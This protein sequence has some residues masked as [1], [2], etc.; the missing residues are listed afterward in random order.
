MHAVDATQRSDDPVSRI[1]L[2]DCG[3]T[4]HHVSC[5]TGKDVLPSARLGV[6]SWRLAGWQTGKKSEADVR[7][8]DLYGGEVAR[9]SLLVRS[10]NVRNV[11]SASQL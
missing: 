10:S 5:V 2:K 4:R 9:V 3:L 7:R 6:K 8:A 1:T 11:A